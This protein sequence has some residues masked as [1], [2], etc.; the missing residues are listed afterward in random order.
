MDDNKKTSSKTFSNLSVLAS[1]SD[2]PN[3]LQVIKLLLIYFGDK[4][5]AH[6]LDSESDIY[7]IKMPQQEGSKTVA[8]AC[9]APSTED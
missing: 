8:R 2:N 3:T 5:V 1:L 9:P 6:W 4:K 7:I